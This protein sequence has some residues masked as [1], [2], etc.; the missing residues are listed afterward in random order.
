[1]SNQMKLFL[2]SLSFVLVF[3]FT[4]SK[5]VEATTQNGTDQ[6]GTELEENLKLFVKNSLTVNADGSFTIDKESAENYLSEDQILQ[7]ENSFKQLGEDKIS[8]LYQKYGDTNTQKDVTSIAKSDKVITYAFPVAIP[9]AMGIWEFL[10]WLAVVS[11]GTIVAAFTNYM[12]KYGVEKA[13]K[14]Y[15][16]KNRHIKEWCKANGHSII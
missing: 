5:P 2:L 6:N 16:S 10:G 11:G 14:K 8:K 3:S 15:S 9:I 4:L 12:I 13:C 1:M 7:I